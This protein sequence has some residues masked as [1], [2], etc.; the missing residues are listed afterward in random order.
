MR[1]YAAVLSGILTLAALVTSSC[2]APQQQTIEV[3]R[4]VIETREVSVEVTREITREVTRE[5]TREAD[6][7]ARPAH[8]VI[9]TSESEADGALQFV[10][11]S[12][13]SYTSFS[14][15]VTFEIV[16][17][18]VETLRDDFLAGSLTGT[19]PDLL[20]TVSGHTRP[21]VEAELILPVD[22]VFDLDKYVAPARAAVTLKGQVWGVPVSNGDHLML[23][24]NRDQVGEPPQ[25]TDELIE[26]GQTLTTGNQYALVYNQTDPWWLVPWLGG[27]DGS[28]FAEDGR[29][30]TLE[31]PEMVRTLQFLQDMIYQSVIV[32]SGT[33]YDGSFVLFSEGRAAMTIDGE[34]ALDRYRQTLGDKLGVARIPRVSAT[35][36]WP[37][38][39]TRGT[40]L[41]FPA[42]LH[43]DRTKLRAAVSFARFVTSAQT[44]A[45]Q[46][47][48]L[49]RLPALKAALEDPL[50]ADDPV[51]RGSVDQLEVSVPV[52]EVSEMRCNWDAMRPE[53][54]AVLVN[55]K[56]PEQA[57]A[58]M[59]QAA[60]RC[61]E[62]LEER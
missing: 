54:E 22:D 12:A 14:P 41:L 58:D 59:Q 31:T 23:I 34:W 9:W 37:H 6:D 27:F 11:S 21:F 47:T 57:A 13:D 45:L 48:K 35:G 24:Y 56:P 36:E 5:V 2:A 29:T 43:E 42:R 40:C 7:E 3:T 55:Q 28:V 50:I 1:T 33:D 26:I 38:P 8:I 4:I 17:K 44:Q 19:M 39:Y 52:P 60:Q 32:P 10:R 53:M 15:G 46:M 18:D 25:N 49:D 51:I 16:E 20:W 30:P 62:K 61:V